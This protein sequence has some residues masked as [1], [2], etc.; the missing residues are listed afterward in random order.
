[1]LKKKRPE[2]IARKGKVSYAKRDPKS[3]KTI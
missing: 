2:P 1:M 3:N